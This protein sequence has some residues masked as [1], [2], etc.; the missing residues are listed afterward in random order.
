[1]I[2]PFEWYQTDSTL[3]YARSETR[4]RAACAPRA[5]K[6]CHRSD[7]QKDRAETVHARFRPALEVVGTTKKMRMRWPGSRGNAADSSRDAVARGWAAAVTIALGPTVVL[8]VGNSTYP[9][10]FPRHVQ[11]LLDVVDIEPVEHDMST[12]G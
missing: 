8:R 9:R 11:Y 5:G 12:M 1:M 3:K 10:R 6:R 4:Y 7:R 2:E